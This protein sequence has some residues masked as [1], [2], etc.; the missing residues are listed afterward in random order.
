[1]HTLRNANGIHNR[2]GGNAKLEKSKDFINELGAD[3]VAYNEHCQNLRHR[4]NRNGWNQ[5]FRGG[6]AEVRSVVAHNVHEADC[7]GRCQEGGTALLMFGPLTEY[8]DTPECVKDGT[9]DYDGP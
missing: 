7:I 6:E 9:V 2:M 8:L 5:L 4:D 1:M 3:I